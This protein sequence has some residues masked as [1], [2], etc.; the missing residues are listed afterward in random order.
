MA[1]QCLIL[2]RDPYLGRG[3]AAIL[4]AEKQSQATAHKLQNMLEDCVENYL[5]VPSGNLH[6]CRL[7]VRDT[8]TD[9]SMESKYW[10]FEK[11]Y[12]LDVVL[13]KFCVA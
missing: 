11:S 7:N 9:L 4:E 3:E 5:H 1:I 12:N 6:F 10:L 13:K 8:W 2:W